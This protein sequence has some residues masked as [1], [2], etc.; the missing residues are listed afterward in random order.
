[1]I[2]S[3]VTAQFLVCSQRKHSMGISASSSI[4]SKWTNTRE[5]SVKEGFHLSLQQSRNSNQKISR[6]T[7]QCTLCVNDSGKERIEVTTGKIWHHPKTSLPSSLFNEEEHYTTIFE[8][9]L[10]WFDW[11]ERTK[12]TWTL[13]VL[14]GV[15][16]RIV[17]SNKPFYSLYSN[18]HSP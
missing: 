7:P 17:T 4:L 16:Y 10:V 3:E 11:K 13:E 5:Q 6:I 12:H 14:I 8:P 2:C 1:M 9:S 18:V 15:D